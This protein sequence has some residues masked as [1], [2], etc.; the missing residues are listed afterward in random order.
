MYYLRGGYSRPVPTSVGRTLVISLMADTEV[1]G[2]SALHDLIRNALEGYEMNLVFFWG[3]PKIFSLDKI[4]V[5][6]ICNTGTYAD[7]ISVI[8]YVY[9]ICLQ[10]KNGY[11]YLYPPFSFAKCYTKQYNGIQ[12]LLCLRTD[13]RISVWYS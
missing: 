12:H 1:K 4:K 5:D 9:T 7:Y 13:W 2:T 8:D 11:G 3:K 6:T 10:K